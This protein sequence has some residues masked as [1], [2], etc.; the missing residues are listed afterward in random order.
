MTSWEVPLSAMRSQ[1]DSALVQ[2]STGVRADEEARIQKAL[3][4]VAKPDSR[5]QLDLNFFIPDF[6]GSASA[7]TKIA[8][9][10]EYQHASRIFVTPDNALIEIRKRCLQDS[11]IMVLPSYGLTQGFLLLDPKTVEPPAIRYAAWLDGIQHFSTVVTLA[12][13]SRSGPF[14]L[15]IAGAAAVTKAG[16]RFGMGHR[17]LDIEWGL[18]AGIKLLSQSTP[19]ATMVHSV[20]LSSVDLPL[21][22]GDVTAD[23]IAF[24]DSIVR[25][26]PARRLMHL[27]EAMLSPELAN[28]AVVQEYRRLKA[29]A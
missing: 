4:D 28:T 6:D 24:S 25:P 1:L 14:D 10:S 11:K 16:L 19:V 22:R 27:E 18:L 23:I 13:L 20:Q 8:S 12:E 5:Y 26:L 2:P 7:A 21:C 15:V 29:E 9:T 17:Y 3:L